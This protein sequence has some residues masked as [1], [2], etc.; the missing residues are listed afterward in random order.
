MAPLVACSSP[1]APVL[2]G[3]PNILIILV[4]D[5]G[6]SDIG[7]FGGEVQTPNIDRLA[8]NGLKFSQMYNTAKCYPTRASLL[9]G[10]YFQRTDR[11]FSNTATLGE[12]LRPAGYRTL[13][14][15]KHHAR[16]N[17]M[18]RGFDRFYGLLGGAQNHFNPGSKAAPGQPAP[19]G[20][21]DGNRWV[22]N[23]NEVRD[24]IPTDPKFYDTDAFTDEALKWLDEYNEE[25]K[26]FL[27]Y[28]SYTAPH[29]P[30]QAW[31]EDVAKYEGVYDEG[32]EIIRNAR[33]Q[34]QIELGLI[35]PE[36]SPLPPMELAKKSLKWGDLSP[37]ERRNQIML[38]QLYAAM[39]DR[40]DQNIGRLINRL[41]KQGKLN[42]T[43]ILFLSD[44]GACAEYPKVQVVDPEAPIGSVAS[45]PS[46]GTNWA[47]V[48]NTPLRKWKTSSHEGG[49]RTPMVVHWPAAIKPQDGWNRDPVHLIDIMPTVLSVAGADY[50]RQSGGSRIPAPDG[51]SLLPAFQGQPLQRGEPLYFEFNKGAAILDG[52]WKLVRLGLEWELYDMKVDMTETNNLAQEHPGI[53]ESMAA[54]WHRWWTECTGMR[55]DYAKRKDYN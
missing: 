7:C 51:L 23:G 53:V 45:Y 19:A 14:S 11:D 22:I 29:W 2:T 50:P 49:I 15:G 54:S 42:N 47:T 10:V 31:P 27:L 40:V 13:W 48:S 26:P 4:D 8:E 30:L 36:T 55:Y 37:D 21:G 24:F 20:K 43:M 1:E 6:Y 32:Y 25:E 18:D 35:D 5:M 12:V 28:M 33:Y 9:T 3:Q 52:K 38:M 39:I 46:Y 16:F 44:N 34:R 17:P 41:E